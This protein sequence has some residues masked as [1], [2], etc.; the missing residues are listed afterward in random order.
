G[1]YLA[2]SLITCACD[3]IANLKYGER[4]RGD[5]IFA[6]LLPTF[7]TPVAKNVYRAV[8]DGI[9]HIYETKTVRIGSRR[10]NIVISWGA[11]PHLHL[12]P[13]GNDLYINVPRLA[14]DLK[15]DL[16]RL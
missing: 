4:Y 15:D 2:A 6:E 5:L 14:Q 8:R 10:L 11:K 9:V 16:N 1:N 3:A 12:S 7:W 13:T